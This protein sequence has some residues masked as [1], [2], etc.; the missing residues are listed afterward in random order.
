MEEANVGSLDMIMKALDWLV[1][2]AYLNLLWLG[3][4]LL[5]LIVFGI[6][7]ATFAVHSIVKK[8]LKQGD[9]SHVFTKFKN[10]FKKYSK[11]GNIYF[12]LVTAA[13]LFIYVDIRVIQALPQNSFIQMAVLPALIILSALVLIV[14]TFTIGIYLEFNHSLQKS[15][16][17]GFWLA[18]ISP[19]AALVMVHAFLVGF[20]IYA[21]V[22]A[23][24]LFYSLSFYAFITQ[25]VMSKT[26]KR[27]KKKKC[28]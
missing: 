10:E 12:G 14:A 20:L 27:I 21:Y 28:L 18:L 13:S 23:L 25:W 5:G 26:F 24:M 11:D 6:G 17:D 19:V 22:P 9:L 15:I 2:L 7:P 4:S 1:T 3:F 8:K 16:K